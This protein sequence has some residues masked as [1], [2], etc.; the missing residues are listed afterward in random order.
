MVAWVVEAALTASAIE[1]VW[2]ATDAEAI[3][4]EA[5]AAGARAILVTSECASGTDRVAAAARSVA[6]D[7]Y[8]NLQGDEPLV[9]PDDIDALACV[10]RREA[11]TRMATLARPLD[12]PED[13]A[14]PDVV[15]VVCDA[16]GFA[17]YF[18]RSPIPYCRGRGAGPAWGK[19]P[20]R[21]LRHLGAYAFRA[22]ALGPSR[23]FPR[24][25]SSGRNAWSSCEP[26]RPAG[27]FGSS[28]PGASRWGWIARRICCARRRRC[29]RA[30]TPDGWAVESRAAGS[31]LGERGSIEGLSPGETGC[32]PS[33]S[34]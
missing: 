32:A 22:E 26:S 34:S 14:S 7:V 31:P 13:L 23:N 2:V 33:S 15:K 18:S 3:A 19:G 27:G 6:A 29:G 25:N 28:P 8:V 20:V 12:R 11:G 24:E 17:L 21:P 4:H 1:E 5:E 9:E 30:S 10:F 16:A